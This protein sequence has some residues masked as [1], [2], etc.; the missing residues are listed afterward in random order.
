M[1]ITDIF[2]VYIECNKCK[3]L[4]IIIFTIAMDIKRET[5]KIQLQFLT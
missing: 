5:N 1:F 4:V 2:I 3:F